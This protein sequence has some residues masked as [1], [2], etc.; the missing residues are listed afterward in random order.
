M[1][2]ARGERGVSRETAAARACREQG[3]KIGDMLEG[4]IGE[5]IVRIRITAIGE[6][7]ILARRPRAGEYKHYPR[8]LMADGFRKVG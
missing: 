4:P 8:D 2:T 5:E 7:A 3:W 6:A 1:A